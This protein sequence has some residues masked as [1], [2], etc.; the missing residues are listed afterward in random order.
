ML[1]REAAAV[2]LATLE[3]HLARRGG[4]LD[5]GA[6]RH[7]GHALAAT[8]AEAHATLDDEGNLAA[9]LHGHLAAALVRVTTDGAVSVLAA[10]AGAPVTAP[11]LLQGGRLTPRADVFALG[12]ILA[13]LL[14]DGSDEELRAALLLAATPEAARR[15]IT[16]VELEALLERGADLDAGRRAL[17]EAVCACLEARDRPVA[18]AASRP[19]S[20]PARVGVA[21]LTAAAV[22][23]AGV[24]VAERWLVR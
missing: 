13:P 18:A 10:P 15:R 19:L 4:R 11:E 16:C 14:A 3:A 23:A 9:V 22:F 8:L 12:T 20:M 6:A 7:L 2:D 24:A 17:G 1:A 5:E 21:L